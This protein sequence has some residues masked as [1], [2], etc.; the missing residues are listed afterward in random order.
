MIDWSS[1][2]ALVLGDVMLDRYLEGDVNR[3]SPEA[4]V[5]VVRLTHEWY[6]PGGAGNVAASLAG[7]GCRTTLAGAAGEDPEVDRLRRALFDAGVADCALVERP[8]SR[9]I[10]KTRVVSHGHHQLLRLDQDGGRN[11]F[12]AAGDDLRQ[13]LPDLLADQDVVVLSDYDKGTLTPELV[14]ATIEACRE[15]AIPCIVDPKQLD[16]RIYSGATL[17]TPNLLEARRAVGRSLEDDESV[18]EAC[19]ELRDT[20]GLDAMLIT[21]GA[22]GMTLAT[23]SALH[24]FPAEVRQVA[25]VTGA[26]DTVAAVLAA[27]LGGGLPVD[28]ACRA[29]SV[30]AGIAVGHPGCYVVQGAELDWALRGCSPKVRSIEAAARWAASQRRAGRSIVFTNGCFDIL[31]AGHLTCLEQARRLGDALIIGLNSDASVRGLKGPERPVVHENHRAALLAGLACVDGVVVF[32]DPTPE[33]LIQA[34]EPDVLVKGGDYTVDGIVGAEI[35]RAKGGR[36]VT[37]PL[38]PGLST[39]SILAAS[40]AAENRRVAS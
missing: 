2:R 31:H 11:D 26:G 16:F 29:A 15:R 33:R 5:P 21:R 35:V 1:V 30:A 40:R 38:V 7:L 34:I 19:A 25:D 27:C 3:I 20:L 14:R 9:T 37:I 23:G 22:D 32:D 17:L 28:Q 4:P 24:H 8:G 6:R 36:V 10:C 18:G 39:T 12:R 13:R